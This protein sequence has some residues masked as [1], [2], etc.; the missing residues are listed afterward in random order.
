[1]KILIISD[2]QFGDRAADHIKNKFQNTKICYIEEIER[3]QL[4]NDYE[5]SPKIESE[6][7]KSDLIIS[8]IRHPDVVFD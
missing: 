4:I 7:L 6:I 1:M 5:F 8:Y 3:N 2:G